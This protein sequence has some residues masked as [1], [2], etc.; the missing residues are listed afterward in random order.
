MIGLLANAGHYVWIVHWLA[1][2][3]PLAARFNYQPT[4]GSLSVLDKAR[5]A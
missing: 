4:G 3:P 1:T 5:T 2:K